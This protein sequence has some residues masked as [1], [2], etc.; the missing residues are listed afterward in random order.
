MRYQVL[1]CDVD[2]TLFDFQAAEKTALQ[3]TLSQSGISADD[4]T[5]KLYNRL[6]EALWKKLER[7]ETTQQLLKVE[8]FRQLLEKLGRPGDALALAELYAHEL[9]Q[10]AQLMPGAED[11]MKTVSQKMPVYLVTNGIT[12]IQ[13]SRL[14]L[15]SLKPYVS[16]MVIS[17]EVGVKKPD[18]K[19]LRIALELSGHTEKEAVMLG[20]SLTADIAAAQNA[21]VDSIWLHWG[22]ACGETG[23]THHAGDLSEALPIIL[24]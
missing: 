12:A 9:G 4:H 14:A 8:R 10:C 22:K 23:A 13:K 5:C 6:N 24:G 18:P 19:M 7:G 17:E 3:C 15:S 16:G 21:G 20:D 11:F 2:D 1:L